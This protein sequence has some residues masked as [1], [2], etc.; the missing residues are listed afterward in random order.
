M[1]SDEI[2]LE[3]SFDVPDDAVWEELSDDD[4]AFLTIEE[5]AQLSDTE[6]SA[7]RMRRIRQLEAE[8]DELER[9]F[10]RTWCIEVARNAAK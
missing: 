5:V 2:T 1:N 9:R 7:M 8:Q 10:E 6:L 4:I 3:M